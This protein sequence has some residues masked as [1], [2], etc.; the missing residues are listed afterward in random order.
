MKEEEENIDLQKELKSFVTYIDNQSLVIWSFIRDYYGVLIVFIAVLG[1][2]LQF[3]KLL[4][5]TPAAT[6]YYA[7]K[8]G[9][10][11]GVL[12]TFFTLSLLTYYAVVFGYYIKI[13]LS[14]N[15]NYRLYTFILTF[16]YNAIFINLLHNKGLIV[17]AAV[18]FGV[19]MVMT[20][21]F[22]FREYVK[23]KNVERATEKPLPTRTIKYV[24]IAAMLLIN[25]LFAYYNL[26]QILSAKFNKG[27]YNYTLLESN[28]DKAGLNNFKVIY[29][30]GDYLF[31]QNN[32]R[33]TIILTFDI[34]TKDILKTGQINT[35]DKN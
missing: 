31:L 24:F 26:S 4:Y 10:I 30:N 1:G 7:P 29:S 21:I 32:Y 35:N 3:A 9:L 27:I 13:A 15:F 6:A 14:R 28:L 23:S 5:I 16:S 12:F 11:D 22:F 19:P 18:V 25:S 8:Q 34:A 20:S 17:L 33:K 2:S